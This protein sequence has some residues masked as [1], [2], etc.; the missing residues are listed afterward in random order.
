MLS[1]LSSLFQVQDLN[2]SFS[3]P[4]LHPKLEQEDRHFIQGTPICFV[5]H[6]RVRQRYHATES[7]QGTVAIVRKADFPFLLDACEYVDMTMAEIEEDE[8]TM[9]ESGIDVEDMMC[10]LLAT[11]GSIAI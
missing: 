1:P 7:V 8:R 6:R 11:P 4:K 3:L 2:V 10:E 5:L 9:W